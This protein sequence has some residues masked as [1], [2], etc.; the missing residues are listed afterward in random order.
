MFCRVVSDIFVTGC[1]F[2][3]T[4]Q[5]DHETNMLF[6]YSFITWYKN[7]KLKWYSILINSKRNLKLEASFVKIFEH[8]QMP[9]FLLKY[10]FFLRMNI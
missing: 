8:L 3:N 10:Q 6:Y 7:V 4:N 5:V 9:L 1:S 2:G